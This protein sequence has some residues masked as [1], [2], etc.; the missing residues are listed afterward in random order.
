MI[1]LSALFTLFARDRALYLAEEWVEHNLIPGLR[2]YFFATSGISCL[3]VVFPGPADLVVTEAPSRRPVPAPH[4]ARGNPHAEWSQTLAPGG[5]FE[6]WRWRASGAHRRVARSR[7]P[8]RQA[9]SPAYTL[10][11]RLHAS[12]I[13]ETAGLSMPER[14]IMAVRPQQRLVRALLDD[15]AMV[16]HDQAIHAGDGREPMGDRDHGLAGH[17]RAEALLDRGLDLAV[18]RG[19]C[20]VQHQDW[21]IFQDD[22][23]NRDALAL[24]AGELDA[25][26]THV[27]IVTAPSAPVF[28][29]RDE[30][31]GVGKP[32]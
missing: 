26:L 27:C 18:E 20:L 24:A 13:D 30:P 11:R 16:E 12:G 19:G 23:R 28:Q 32:G 7:A 22:A 9:A 2:K 1:H 25:A 15:A 17:E 8:P 6:H 31:I 3:R 14:S 29:L 21:R 5:R 4:G 10:L